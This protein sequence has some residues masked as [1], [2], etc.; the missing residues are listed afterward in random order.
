VIDSQIPPF[1]LT[2]R[3]AGAS[4]KE[5][6]VVARHL[7]ANP[8]LEQLRKQAKE[9][10]DHV[11]SGHPKAVKGAR[12]LHPRW[13]GTPL[14]AAEWA[15]FTLADAQLVV[16]RSYGFPS[17]RRFREN[18]DLI[19][20][21]SRS[22][23]R[24]PA[25]SADLVH[26]FLRL[27]CLNHCDGWNVGAGEEPDDLR[28]QAE[29]RRLLAAHPELASATIHTAAAVGD[30]AAARSLLAAD[31]SLANDQGGP[32]GWPP[33][34][35]LT[36]SRLNT[37]EKSHSTL[38]VARLLLAHGADPNAGYL[39]DGEPP[40]V[41]ALS[42]AF[43]GERD[44]VNQPAHQHGLPLARLLLDAGADP[45]DEQ[46]LRNACGYPHDDDTGLALLL[47]H[48]LGR[49]SG[50]PWRALLEHQPGDRLPTPAGLVQ[51]ELRYSAQWNLPNRVRLL[52]RRCAETGIDIDTT[53]G[54]AG[55]DPGHPAYKLAVV[56]GNTEIVDLLTRAGANA[57]PPDQTH[58]FIAACQ[59]ADRAAV[60]RL[61]A[62]DPSLVERAASPPCGPEPLHLAVALNRPEAVA[63]MASLGFPINEDWCGWGPP[64]HTAA[65]AGH[66][67]IVRLLVEL[68]ADPTAK[69]PDDNDP[70]AEFI[71]YDRTPLGWARYHQHDEVVAYLTRRTPAQ[72]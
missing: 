15:G 5:A 43:R 2:M 56:C 51:T 4:R 1:G 58:Q 72:R 14:G 7:P 20:R 41:T 71:Q 42:G 49:R 62:A 32:H 12:E 45:N 18:V 57:E 50:G 53:G 52:L 60:H 39:P 16:A 68:G 65:L 55:R 22:P 8:S 48:G 23:Q 61:L 33:L 28:R 36:F 21:Y 54:A 47:E 70:S 25:D 37:T 30:L 10:R 9:V 67:D 17:W 34:L 64:L 31:P 6:A 46:A 29:A 26:E 69:A 13:A 24:R 27:A 38:E 59:R 3:T 66:L 63:L 35:Y 11:R 19:A 44:P 40:P